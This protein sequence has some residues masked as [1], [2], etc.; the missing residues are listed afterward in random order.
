[1]T[2]IEIRKKVKV[3]NSD[4]E[5]IVEQIDRTHPSIAVR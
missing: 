3:K 4:I 2:E 5:G 1:M